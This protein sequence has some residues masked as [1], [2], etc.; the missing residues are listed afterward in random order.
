LLRLD[1]LLADHLGPLGQPLPR[2][3]QPLAPVLQL[4]QLDYSGLVRIEEPL[5]LPGESGLLALHPLQLPLAIGQRRPLAC[6]LL[7]QVGEN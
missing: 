4:L 5:V 3:S 6:L 2:L 1:T 7:A